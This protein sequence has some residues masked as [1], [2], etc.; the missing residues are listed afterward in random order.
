MQKLDLFY[1][2][3]LCV[4]SYLRSHLLRSKLYPLERKTGMRNAIRF[5]VMLLEKV[6]KLIIIL[7][8]IVN[9]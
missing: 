8:A 1:T 5:L 9:V 2:C 6:L 4:I 7:I 3:T